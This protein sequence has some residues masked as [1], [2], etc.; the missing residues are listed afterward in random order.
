[1][2][3]QT[4]Q[5]YNF[6][7]MTEQKVNRVDK[8]DGGSSLS[9]KASKPASKSAS[10][11]KSKKKYRIR[12][13]THYI[14]SDTF[15]VNKV[16][17]GIGFYV[18]D[19]KGSAR[20]MMTFTYDYEYAPGLVAR[21]NF[22]HE[23]SRIYA[24]K[25]LD[26]HRR[27]G[28][29]IQ[30]MK[31]NAPIRYDN[32]HDLV[33]KSALDLTK[34]KLVD[35]IISMKAEDV[36]TIKARYADDSQAQTKYIDI[37]HSWLQSKDYRSIEEIFE[38]R[39]N[40]QHSDSDSDEEDNHKKHDPEIFRML[41]KVKARTKIIKLGSKK[42]GYQN[43]TMTMEA[44]YKEL[45]KAYRMNHPESEYYF[46][47]NMIISPSSHFMVM[48]EKTMTINFRAD[49]SKLEYKLNKAACKRVIKRRKIEQPVVLRS[50]S[51]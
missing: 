43:E 15:D 19:P 31:L 6:A 9:Q 2:K 23:K 38:K 28:N 39:R 16:R 49:C 47:S 44:F 33:L 8:I 46:E 17:I 21:L 4:L 25:I 12:P 51:V 24:S 18:R 45:E 26:L 10:K 14:S 13:K 40:V 30:Y 20:T 7:L 36:E 41:P 42:S 5:F 34:S 27:F 35:F 3:I 48:G 37:F 50:L 1:V 22:L 32:P 11:T 29:D